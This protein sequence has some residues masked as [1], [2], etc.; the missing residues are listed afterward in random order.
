MQSFSF[1]QGDLDSVFSSSINHDQ[2]KKR[3]NYTENEIYRGEPKHKFCASSYN[4]SHHF[5][6]QINLKSHQELYKQRDSYTSRDSTSNT[7]NDQ[8]MI[9]KP[10][11]DR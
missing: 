1:R 6:E 7:E 4:F 10:K 5:K 2:T 9:I 3:E 11:I 8:N